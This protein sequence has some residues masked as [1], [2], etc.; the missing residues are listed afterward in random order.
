MKSKKNKTISKK[1]SKA[2]EAEAE[3]ED[4]EKALDASKQNLEHRI[5]ALKK[6]IRQL[7]DDDERNP[8]EI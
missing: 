1:S 4:N 7:S 6:I 5:K 3:A 8:K 2:K